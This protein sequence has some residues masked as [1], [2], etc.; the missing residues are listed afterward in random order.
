MPGVKGLSYRL[1]GEYAS[2]SR[3]PYVVGP[4]QA[5][6]TT[7]TAPE[8]VPVVQYRVGLGLRYDLPF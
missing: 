5:A 6:T 3:N 1:S 8:L 7:M 2:G 4:L